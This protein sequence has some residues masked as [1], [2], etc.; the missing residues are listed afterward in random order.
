MSDR[1]NIQSQ[2][3]HLQMKYV[4]TGHADTSKAEWLAAQHKD[5][6]ASY[7]GH[8][9][10]LAY[11]A[12]AQ[13]QSLGRVRYQMLQRMC[14]PCEEPKPEAGAAVASGAAAN[15]AAKGMQR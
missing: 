1:F 9:S 7:I 8:P 3:E 12:T 2:L 4:G 13:N 6:Y 11:F 5:S 14:K 10:L 15:G